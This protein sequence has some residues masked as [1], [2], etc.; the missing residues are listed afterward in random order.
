MTTYYYY[1]GVPIVLPSSTG[2]IVDGMP[3]AGTR[4]LLS[5][6]R[7][8]Q[9]MGINPLFFNQGGQVNTS[10]GKVIFPHSSAMA[11]IDQTW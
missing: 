2:G 8:A 4:T 5:I 6:D 11:N 7:Y 3:V 10:D 9:I 1:S